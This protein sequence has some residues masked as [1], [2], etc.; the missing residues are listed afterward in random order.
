MGNTALMMQFEVL[1]KI[2]DNHSI[3][4]RLYSNNTG[5][6]MRSR[7][8]NPDEMLTGCDLNTDWQLINND[9]LNTHH[10]FSFPSS[11]F[12]GSNLY[13]DGEYPGNGGTPLS[14]HIDHL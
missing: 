4:V 2:C 6:K 8:N 7:P 1:K 5:A 11:Q 3:D 14:T 12:N 9:F 10:Y 13:K